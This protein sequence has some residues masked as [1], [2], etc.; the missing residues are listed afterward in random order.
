MKK[1]LFLKVWV[2]L[3]GLTLISA[4]V[5]GSNMLYATILIVLLSIVKFIGVSFYF[6]E[7]RKA[8]VFWKSSVLIFILLF[9]IITIILI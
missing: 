7:L 6:M 4:F 2:A 1:A 9:S 8:H 5:S 3:I